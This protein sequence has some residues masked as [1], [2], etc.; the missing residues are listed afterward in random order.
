M[1]FP[2][3]QGKPLPEPIWQLPVVAS[4]VATT[5]AFLSIISIL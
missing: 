3:L 2:L 4:G 1:S 5:I